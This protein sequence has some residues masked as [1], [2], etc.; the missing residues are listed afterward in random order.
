M[1]DPPRVAG[2]A[3]RGRRANSRYGAS[4]ARTAWGR[5]AAGH[6]LTYK[7]LHDNAA[8]DVDEAVVTVAANPDVGEPKTGN[9]TALRVHR[10]RVLGEL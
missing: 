7:K 2:V 6:V 5:V 9:L 4:I 10:F 8:T 1:G 3:L